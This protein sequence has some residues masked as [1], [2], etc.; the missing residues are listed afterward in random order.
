MKSKQTPKIE[1]ST[2]QYLPITAIK[3]GAV[4]LN[5]HSLRA[6]ILVSSV[7]F[8]LK[9]EDEKNSVLTSFQEFLNGLTFPIQM[10]STSRSLDLTNYL[11]SVTKSA[12]TQKNPLLKLQAEEYVAFVKQLLEVANIMEKRFYVV[13]PYYPSGVDAVPGVGSMFPKKETSPINSSFDEQR[14]HLLE[15]VEVTIQGLTSLGLRAAAL[16]TDDLLELYY[17]SYNPDSAKNQSIGGVDDIDAT[18]VQG[19]K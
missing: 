11:A 17:A 16:G 10:L 6:V 1:A 15:R 4:L 18:I 2:Q 14:K 9:S 19:A 12:G 5:D 13:V 7:N 8:A 3:E